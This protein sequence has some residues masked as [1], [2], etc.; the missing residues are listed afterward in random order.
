[1]KVLK[2]RVVLLLFILLLPLN[3]LSCRNDSSSIDVISDLAFNEKNTINFIY[4]QEGADYVP[5]L[6]LTNDY[7]GYTLLLRKNVMDEPKRINSY[8]SYYENSEID[9][10]LN[11]EYLELLETSLPVELVDLVVTSESSLGT[12]KTNT[13]TIERKIFLLS[14]TEIGVDAPNMG[15]EG[16]FLAYFECENNRLAYCNNETSGW[17][18]RTPNTYYDSCVYSVGENNKIGY[19][20]AF[21]SNGIRPAFCVKGDLP[22][23]LKNG[24][25]ENQSV[26]VFS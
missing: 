7:N 9:V 22:V 26:Y 24:I 25:V 5:F 19:S 16:S 4:V 1:M 10:Y 12:T 3:L 6:V 18:L 15:E 21:D 17:W 13:A 2:T 8:S 11:N 20:N 23:E 14:C